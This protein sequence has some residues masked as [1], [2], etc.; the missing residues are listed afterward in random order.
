MTKKLRQKF[1]YLENEKNF[2][3]EIKS[4]F[5]HFYKAFI[6]A[7]KK[8]FFLEGVSPTLSHHNVLFYFLTL[9][10][11]NLFESITKKFEKEL[12]LVLYDL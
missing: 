3:D 8:N 7:N 9:L 5:H 6:E 12:H 10:S 2:Y 1:K 11:S 4:I